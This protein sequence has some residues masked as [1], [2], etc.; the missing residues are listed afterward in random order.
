[1]YG[2]S[3]V[4]SMSDASIS[5]VMRSR[6]GW[7]PSTHDLVKQPAASPSSLDDESRLATITGLKTFSSKCPCAPAKVIAAWLPTTCAQTIVSA[8]HCVG[9]TFPGMIELPG[10]FSGRESSPRP[11]R[12]PLPRKRMS[13]AILL[14][15][16]ASTFSAPLASMIAS[17]AASASNLLGA[18]TKGSCV[19]SAMSRAI[20]T[21][22]PSVVL[23]PVPTAVPPRASSYKWGSTERTRAMPLCTCLA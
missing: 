23:R 19:S 5:A 8:S 18:V 4:T 6:L 21:S 11:E 2:L 7:M 10:S 12:G 3:A 22:Y 17:C 15:E 9:L 14:S 1:M 20:S 16:H 13:F